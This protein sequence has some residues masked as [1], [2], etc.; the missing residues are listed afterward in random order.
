[1][2]MLLGGG[3]LIL[4]GETALPSH[5]MARTLLFERVSS[6]EQQK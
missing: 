1:M 3:S 6:M 5:G 4:F 2:F